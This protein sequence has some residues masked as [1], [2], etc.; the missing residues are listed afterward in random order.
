MINADREDL[1]FEESIAPPLPRSR[2]RNAKEA[3]RVRCLAWGV[4]CLASAGLP[5]ALGQPNAPKG[6]APVAMVF[7]IAVVVTVFLGERFANSVQRSGIPIRIWRAGIEL[8]TSWFEEHVWRRPRVIGP[9]AIDVVMVSTR[10]RDRKTGENLREMSVRLKNGGL[11][12]SGLKRGGEVDRMAL[13][14]SGTWPFVR[15][16]PEVGA[17]ASERQ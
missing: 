12:S 1:L 9:M 11:R 14:I 16:E 10:G 3:F 13:A 17:G 4:I 7:T 5:L 6:F 2:A 15:V 8:P